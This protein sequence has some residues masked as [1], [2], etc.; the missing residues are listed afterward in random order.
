MALTSKT[1]KS[2]PQAQ[3]VMLLMANR[4]FFNPAAPVQQTKARIGFALKE[5]RKKARSVCGAC[6]GNAHVSISLK[7]ILINLSFYLS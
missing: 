1:T 4:Q 7:L 3:A 5:L 6:E 2:I